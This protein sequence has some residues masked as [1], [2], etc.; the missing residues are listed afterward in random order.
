MAPIKYNNI[1][2]N[3]YNNAT[4]VY[5]SD[6]I[7]KKTYEFISIFQKCFTFF[8]LNFPNITGASGDHVLT[9]MYPAESEDFAGADASKLD[10]FVF[11]SVKV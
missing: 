9:Y 2:S 7:T 3:I 10:T 6:L 11:D 5:L 4:I 8:K 1:F